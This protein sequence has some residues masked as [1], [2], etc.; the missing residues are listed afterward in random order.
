M[1]KEVCLKIEK[2]HS[3]E[4]DVKE[5]QKKN[6]KLFNFMKAIY[7]LATPRKRSFLRSVR[8]VNNVHKILVASYNLANIISSKAYQLLIEQIGSYDN[9]RFT[10]RDLQN[11]S[12]DLKTLII[13]KQ[14]VDYHK[15]YD[16]LNIMLRITF[17]FESKNLFFENYLNNH[18]NLVEFW[19]RFDSAIKSQRNKK[20]LLNNTNLHS[21]PELKLH[22][23]IEKHGMKI[24][25]HENF[26]IFQIELWRAYVDFGIEETKEK[27]E[28]LLFLVLESVID[29]DSE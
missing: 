14:M 8:G 21:R 18:L 9:I 27:D 1:I 15:M 13:N 20:K 3:Q 29:S 16:I 5:I 28:K 17:R 22:K 24:Y 26:Y 10:Q 12:R 7:I 4:K 25:T 19:M 2:E 6:M 11:Y 23:D